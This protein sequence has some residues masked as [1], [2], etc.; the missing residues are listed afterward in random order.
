MS[1]FSTSAPTLSRAPPRCGGKIRSVYANCAG[2][3]DAEAGLQ[4]VRPA[5]GDRLTVDGLEVGTGVGREADARRRTAWS[6]IRS[7]A[8]SA[9]RRRPSRRPDRCVTTTLLKYGDSCSDCWNCDH[10]RAVV[11]LARRKRIEAFDQGCVMALAAPRSAA[12]RCD[13]PARCRSRPA[14]RR[15]RSRR[16]RWLPSRR[17]WRPRSRA[18]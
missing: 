6:A 10:L 5:E 1:E 3:V 2:L 7:A 14:A 18:R 9:V 11:G 4:L 13:R 12:R 8:P 16:R 17:L 15:S